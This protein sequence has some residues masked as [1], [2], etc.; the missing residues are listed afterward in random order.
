MG[1]TWTSYS[2]TM[3]PKRSG[4]RPRQ[5]LRS[6]LLRS[7][8]ITGLNERTRYG[9][10]YDVDARLRPYGK[11]GSLVIGASR[12]REY[13]RTEAHAWERL[14]LVK[15]RT[16]AGDAEFRRKLEAIIRDV[17]FRTSARRLARE[18]VRGT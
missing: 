3:T 9:V 4:G 11:Q 13:Y 2:S 5:R 14:A 15:A 1:A 18:Q 8:I 6:I 7:Q 16:V 12:L 10:L 17:C